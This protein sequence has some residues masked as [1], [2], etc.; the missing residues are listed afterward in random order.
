MKKLLLS[1]IL[2]FM[3]FS[4]VNAQD[5]ETYTWEQWGVSFK[6]PAQIEEVEN[7]EYSFIAENE[8]FAISVEAVD[9]E[10]AT[11]DDIAEFLVYL[12]DQYGLS[13]A[14]DAEVDLLSI[15]GFE[16]LYLEGT[17]DEGVIMCVAILL[18]SSS[19]L[20]LAIRIIYL[21]G[22]EE[23]CTNIINSFSKE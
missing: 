17:I 21:E 3:V 22:Q 9:Y 18:D 1:F 6:I 16:G 13:D 12:G 20:A 23:T 15:G 4:A 5:L 7:T 2:L 19:D 8:E 11:I 10:G 14:L